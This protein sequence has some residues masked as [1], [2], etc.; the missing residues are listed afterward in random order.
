ML[1]RGYGLLNNP[2]K[3][4]FLGLSRR[5]WFLPTMH[6]LWKDAGFMKS[7]IRCIVKESFT[8]KK[9]SVLTSANLVKPSADSFNNWVWTLPGFITKQFQI[10]KNIWTI[11]NYCKAE[12]SAQNIQTG[13]HIFQ[14]ARS[15]DTFMECRRGWLVTLLPAHIQY[16]S[17][18][19]NTR[20]GVVLVSLGHWPFCRALGYR[21][22]VEK[23]S[24]S[25]LKLPGKQPQ[26]Q[27]KEILCTTQEWSLN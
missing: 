12:S 20:C 14:L 11:W 10:T 7:G 19:W 21:T 27:M 24:T 1:Q 18:F 23:D 8:C 9:D 15:Q 2:F 13:I 4:A 25:A 16:F 3:S 22:L 17:S 26:T 6:Q 5:V